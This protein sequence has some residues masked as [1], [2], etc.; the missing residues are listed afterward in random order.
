MLKHSIKAVFG[1]LR[2]YERLEE[3]YQRMEVFVDLNMNAAGSE[4]LGKGHDL[5]FMMVD[6]SVL[7]MYYVAKPWLVNEFAKLPKAARCLLDAIV[8]FFIRSGK[9]IV[10]LSPLFASAGLLHYYCA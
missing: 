4:T 7:L 8:G 6:S 1:A 5:F 3:K 10:Y 2:V 9:F